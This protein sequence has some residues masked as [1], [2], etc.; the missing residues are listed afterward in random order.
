MKNK[1]LKISNYT[2][3]NYDLLKLALTHSNKRKKMNNNERLEFLG[4]RVLGLIIANKIYKKFKFENEGELSKR[5]SELVSKKTLVKIAEKICLR[6]HLIIN[7]T[8]LKIDK[9]TNSMLAD[10]M[11][12][13]IAAIFLDSNLDST[14]KIIL[15]LWN[16]EIDNQMYPPDNPKSKLQEWCLKRKESLPVYEIIN[17]EGPDHDPLFTVKLEIKNLISTYGKGKSIQV[18]EINAAENGIKEI[19]NE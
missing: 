19:F 15:S 16:E 17:K 2:F 18:A 10:S 12:A 4:D 14:S 1:T 8:S 5:Y 6:D 7:K 11:E 9:I 3:S 13:L